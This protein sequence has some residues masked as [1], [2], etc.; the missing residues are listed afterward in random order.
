M[1]EYLQYICYT[2]EIPFLVSGG[3]MESLHSIYKKL[4]SILPSIYSCPPS[5]PLPI[6]DDWVDYSKEGQVSPKKKPDPETKIKIETITTTSSTEIPVL[7]DHERKMLAHKE[8]QAE[9]KRR[10]EELDKQLEAHKSSQAASPKT[11]IPKPPETVPLPPQPL[12]FMPASTSSLVAAKGS[13]SL[14]DLTEQ[15][16]AEAIV[17]VPEHPN[18]VPEPARAVPPTEPPRASPPVL[19]TVVLDPRTSAHRK[20]Y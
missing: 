17:P 19:P 12:L 7:S 2:Y 8:K 5:L 10:I 6:A 18:P 13:P 16:G 9:Q 15:P 4:T 1:A 3:A 20:G 14:L 11:V